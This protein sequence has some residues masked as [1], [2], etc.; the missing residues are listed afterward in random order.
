MKLYAGTS[1][2]SYKSW[3]GDF[4]PP[5]IAAKDMLRFYAEQLPAVEI[6]NTFYRSPTP[7]LLRGWR[8]LVP[9][10]FRFAIKAPRR[11]T[12]VKRL[13]DC[14]P[15]VDYL[16][17]ALGVLGSRLGAVLFQLPPHFRLDLPRL[18]EFLAV[19]PP[20]CKAAFEFRHDSWLDAAVIDRLAAK[21]LALVVSETDDRPA[22]SVTSTS[23][24]AYLRL[25]KSSYAPHELRQWAHRLLQSSLREAL[26]FFK[27][28]E[29]A[30]GPR[31]ARALLEA[32]SAGNGQG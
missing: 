10:R 3:K 29:D 4:Y 11:I 27:H 16:F 19:L 2:F 15:E 7:E 28:E 26:V 21:D 13:A 30:A 20:G 5:R 17:A 25:R 31:F 24:W 22:P 14:G 23:D 32:A 8:G 18:D 1:G 9:R 12:H 6:N